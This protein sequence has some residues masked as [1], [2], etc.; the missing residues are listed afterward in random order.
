MMAKKRSANNKQGAQ[1]K[2]SV[3]KSH[4]IRTY[5]NAHPNATNSEV[6]AELTKQGVHVSPNFVATIKAKAKLR[7]AAKAGVKRS[8]ASTPEQTKPASINKGKAVRDYMNSNPRAKRSQVVAALAEQGIHVSASY[9]SGIAAKKKKRRQA[10]KT[11]VQARGVGVPELKA[12][13]ALLKVCET[14]T[15][16]KEAL[17]AAEEIKK[18]VAVKE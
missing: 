3:N 10:V 5:L 14:M 11:V 16:A 8:E 7:R 13:I 15:A 1:G 4:A 6:A 12:A 9:V 2:G 17:V 18:M